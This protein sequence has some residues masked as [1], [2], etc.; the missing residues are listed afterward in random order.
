MRLLILEAAHEPRVGNEEPV[1]V[2]VLLCS[3]LALQRGCLKLVRGTAGSAN[4]FEIY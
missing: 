2:L 4:L 1:K 3:A